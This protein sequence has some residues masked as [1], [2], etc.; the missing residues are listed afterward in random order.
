MIDRSGVISTRICP[1]SSCWFRECARAL[2]ICA[3]G[4]WHR[5][6]ART[7]ACTSTGFGTGRSNDSDPTPPVAGTTTKGRLTGASGCLRGFARQCSREVSAR[8]VW[9]RI[10]SSTA[11]SKCSVAVYSPTSS[12]LLVCARSRLTSSRSA[13]HRSGRTR[14]PALGLSF[15]GRW[16]SA[17][18]PSHTSLC[19]AGWVP[20]MVG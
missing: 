16:W 8:A 14:M 12:A 10:P 9:V 1:P 6:T 18:Y 7:M 13:G 15:T 3:A 17:H 19:A 5:Q 11:A 4:R 20:R 2:A